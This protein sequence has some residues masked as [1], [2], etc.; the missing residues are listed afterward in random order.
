MG[1]RVRKKGGKWFIF[2]TYNGRRKAKCVGSK[3]AAE[4]V[5]RIL[6]ARLALG[7]GAMFNEADAR[8]ATFD[9]YADLWL[10]Q[11][12]AIEN[13]E[14][15]AEGYEGVLRNYLRPRFGKKTLDTI[16]RDELKLMI[17]DLI[18]KKLSRG[19]IKH[20]IAVIRKMFNDAIE[21]G[22][23]Q[24]NPAAR[25]GRFT[26]AAHTSEK[27]GVALTAVETQR[28]LDAA[29]EICPE[30]YPL[31]LTGFR[32]GL[33]RGEL[34]ALQF[35][36]INFGTEDDSS[37]RFILVQHNY[38][39]RKH[40][41]TKSGKSRR[42]DMSRELRRALLEV[43]DQRLLDAYLKGKE[44]ISDELVFLGPDGGILDPD[45]LYHRYFVPVLQK[46]GIRKIRLHDLRHTFGSQ[47]LQKGASIL[48]VKEQMG[49]SSIQVTVDEYGHLIPGADAPFVDR[50]DAPVTAETPQPSATPVQP[51][52]KAET[53][54][55]AEVVD[56]IG[57]GD[58][59]RTSDLRIMRPSL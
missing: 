37:S 51:R 59:T 11:H 35:G 27:A 7:D 14:S 33:R 10:K 3:A 29:S 32:A 21:S 6:E 46:A 18:A 42:V 39:R 26:R 28:F 58:W 16:S 45:N 56:L 49:H 55:P 41:S 44:D 38:V 54:I 22:I 25:L 48:Y 57:G 1:V 8:V 30:Y 40:T 19:T 36:D 20:A 47:L 2:V 23:V 17:S 4:E 5:K 50:L 53:E 34:V 15:T 52:E 12:A 13:K 31:F 24:S 43:R 9:E